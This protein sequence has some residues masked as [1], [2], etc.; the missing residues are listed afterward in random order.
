MA[1]VTV[2]G[3][4]RKIILKGD[5]MYDERPL[6]ALDAY[7]V[8][9]ILPGML[10]EYDADGTVKPHSAAA[11]AASARFAVELAIRMG[12]TIETAYDVSGETVLF[13]NCRSGDWVYAWLEAGGGNVVAVG[14]LLNSNGAGLLQVGTAN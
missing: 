4:P 8:G 2:A 6:K 1:D 3:N 11:G 12:A 14:T 9:A 7:G 5:P 10:I 13:A